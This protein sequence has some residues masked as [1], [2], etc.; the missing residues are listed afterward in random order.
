M[1]ERK[2]IDNESIQRHISSFEELKQKLTPEIVEAMM[3]GAN[4]GNFW[5]N[6]SLE[7]SLERDVTFPTKIWTGFNKLIEITEIAKSQNFENQQAIKE[8]DF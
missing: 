1:N 7:Q 3:N 8:F 2:K 5:D 6:E 4:D